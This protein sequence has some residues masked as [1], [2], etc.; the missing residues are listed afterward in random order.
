MA[1][2]AEIRTKLYYSELQN[3]PK[4]GSGSQKSHTFKLC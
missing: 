4:T 2:G 3:E 1:L